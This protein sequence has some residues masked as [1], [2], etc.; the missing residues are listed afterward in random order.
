MVGLKRW[1]DASQ[2][3]ERTGVLTPAGERAWSL[4]LLHQQRWSEAQ[5]LLS[6]LHQQDSSNAEVLHELIACNGK[7]G[8]L[9]DA[10]RKRY[11]G[12]NHF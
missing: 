11:F 4:A 7:L 8:N 5:P 2:L 12:I 9:D 10:L 6:H 3:F 1:S